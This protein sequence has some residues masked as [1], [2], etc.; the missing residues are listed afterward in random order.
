M[1]LL[2]EISCIK[3]RLSWLP[4]PFCNATGC[5]QRLDRHNIEHPY[6]FHSKPSCSISPQEACPSV[7]DTFVQQVLTP[8]Q[9]RQNK[10]SL[11]QILFHASFHLRSINIVSSFD[12][13]LLCTTTNYQNL[14]VLQMSAMATKTVIIFIFWVTSGWRFKGR[15]YGEDVH[16]T[17]K[18][19][20]PSLEQVLLSHDL[21]V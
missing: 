8:G 12:Q 2:S 1:L 19:S 17:G 21:K 7:M 13:L 4:C 9:L 14:V 15:V 18:H 16:F 20:I 11:S 3:I 10:I 6:I 5:L